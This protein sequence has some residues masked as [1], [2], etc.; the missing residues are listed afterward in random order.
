MP[1]SRSWTSMTPSR[2]DGSKTDRLRLGL[3]EEWRVEAGV[4]LSSGGTAARS[5]FAAI[6]RAA[7]EIDPAVP[8]MRRAAALAS[9]H[10]LA[11]RRRADRTAAAQ[12]FADFAHHNPLFGGCRLQIR[13]QLRCRPD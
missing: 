4:P 3:G 2:G 7:A 1:P 9:D 8:V 11:E 12:A 6:G 5:R 10:R 13:D